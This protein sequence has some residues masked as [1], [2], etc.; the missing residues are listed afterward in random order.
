[1]IEE[2]ERT[3]L[4]CLK[5]YEVPKDDAVGIS[6]FLNKAGKVDEMLEWIKNHISATPEEVLRGALE[7]LNL[8]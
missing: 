4:R 3:L 5:A 7:I 6:L 2:N 1:M 8:N